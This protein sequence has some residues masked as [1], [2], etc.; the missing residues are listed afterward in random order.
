MKKYLLTILC[1]CAALTT[2]AAD[3]SSLI[4]NLLSGSW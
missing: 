1:L 3:D 4:S 2:L